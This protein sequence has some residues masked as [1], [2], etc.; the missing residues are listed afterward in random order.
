MRFILN[1]INNLLKRI[2][3]NYK[4]VLLLD[5]ILYGLVMMLDVHHNALIIFVVAVALYS[6]LIHVLFLV[7]VDQNVIEQAKKTIFIIEMLC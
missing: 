4:D 6:V 3:E 7:N 2:K 5:E 1:I